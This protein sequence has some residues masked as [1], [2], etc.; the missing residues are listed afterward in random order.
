MEPCLADIFCELPPAE[1]LRLQKSLRV[2][3]HPG[4]GRERIKAALREAYRRLPAPSECTASESGRSAFDRLLENFGAL[5]ASAL[6]QAERAELQKHPYTVW[7]DE[8]RTRCYLSGNALE[9]LLQDGELRKA[10]FLLHALFR[11]PVR[12]RRAW[13]RW[14]Q[15]PDLA[16]RGG[17]ERELSIRLYQRLGELRRQERRAASAMG[18]AAPALTEQ[19]E[20]PEFLDQVF[21]DDPHATPLAWF[22]RDILPLY[23]CLA[24]TES[25]LARK[26]SRE[27][28]EAR[29]QRQIIALLKS[30]RIVLRP[31]TPEFGEPLRYHLV[32]TREA[33]PHTEIAALSRSESAERQEVLF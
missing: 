26:V 6:S 14:L 25:L 4:A 28:R 31:N 12:E 5:D 33:L 13:R 24:E 1:L 8:S 32:R 9:R 22:Y 18:E 30:G 27:K 15:S 16:A 10:G 20:L 11:L 2:I 29:L 7:P 21:P 17:S 3:L 19:I 23:Q